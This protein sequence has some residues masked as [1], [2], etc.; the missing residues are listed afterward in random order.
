[1]SKIYPIIWVLG[2]MG[3]FAS[4][5][6]YQIILEKSSAVFWAIRNSDYPHLIID[7]IPVKDLVWSIEDKDSTIDFVA[8][9]A[10]K[11]S[12]MGCTYLCMPCN[13]MHLYES[14]ITKDL[15]ESTKFISMVDVVIEQLIN[16][17]HLNIGII[18]TRTTLESWL[19][20]R[21]IHSNVIINKPTK[22]EISILVNIIEN[23]ISGN[24]T[25]SHKDDLI[26]ICRSLQNKW[27]TAIILW[28]TELP[29]VLSQIMPEL[30]PEI[31]FYD[32]LDL[33]AQKI[34]DIN[35]Q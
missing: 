1:M 4:S 2:W 6:F 22:A 31:Q 17:G 28:C 20:D 16:D 26:K 9:E 25:S 23:V 30:L 10:V 32:P 11:L 35:Y 3:A 27:S 5:R 21:K 12:K 13:T 34:C 19:Y 8:L 18:W 29:I 14:N 24:I 33:L 15:S 7:N